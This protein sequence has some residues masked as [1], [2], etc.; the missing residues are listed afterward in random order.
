[1]E[2]PSVGG[3]LVSNPMIHVL[4]PQVRNVGRFLSHGQVNAEGLDIARAS[5]GSSPDSV[6]RLRHGPRDLSK[7]TWHIFFEVGISWNV[8]EHRHSG[9]GAIFAAQK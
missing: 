6:D 1:M 4:P 2:E 3:S 7:P 8:M 9:Y 5:M